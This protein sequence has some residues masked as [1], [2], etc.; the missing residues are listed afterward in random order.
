MKSQTIQFTRKEEA[1]KIKPT[2]LYHIWRVVGNEHWYYTNGD[3]AIIY[4]GHTYV[5]ATINRSTV[6][7]DST[8]EVTKMT[9]YAGYVQDPA[10]E[11]IAI[12][13]IEILWISVMRVHRDQSPLEVSVIF[14][15]QIKGVKFQGIKAEAEC[16]GFEHF[17]KMPVPTD[18]YQASCNFKLFDSGCKLVKSGY[19]VTA[20]V[21]IDASGTNLTSATFGTYNP[22][23]FMAGSVEYGN[24]KRT[25]VNHDGN[26]VTMAY[27]MR[28][29]INGASV[30]A[31]PGCDGKPDTCRDKFN[32]VINSRWFAFI[33]EEDPA[34]RTP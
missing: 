12:N 10:L 26:V 28:N 29:L 1:A 14:I 5:P 27:R 15:G 17:L 13:P 11:F 7:Y 33:P 32:N 3:M 18:R 22:N 23:Y 19:K 9:L 30:D 24:E 20:V 8:L 2:E 25:I 34:L 6:K 16:V 4:G 21:T 31:Y